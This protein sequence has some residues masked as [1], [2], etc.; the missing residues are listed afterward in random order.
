MLPPGAIMPAELATACGQAVLLFQD[1][2]DAV[3]AALR[4]GG[5]TGGAVAVYA[6]TVASRD[7]LQQ[8]GP[9]VAPPWRHPGAKCHRPP[10]RRHNSCSPCCASS[11]ARGLRKSGWK[12]LPMPPTGR[13]CGIGWRGRRLDCFLAAAS[14]KMARPDGISVFTLWVAMRNRL[15]LD[16]GKELSCFFIRRLK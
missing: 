10:P 4:D 5:T 3:P 14:L 8:P 11:I 12:R 15:I 9:K 7:L 1:L 2:D 16:S 6:R 13:A